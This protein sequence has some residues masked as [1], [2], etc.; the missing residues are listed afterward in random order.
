VP[1]HYRAKAQAQSEQCQRLH[2]IEIAQTNTSRRIL[3]Y[4]ESYR[5]RSNEE[6]DGIGQGWNDEEV[7]NQS[8]KL[9]VGQ[10]SQ[11]ETLKRRSRYLAERPE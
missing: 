11:P 3:E 9:V 6:E 8:Y 7:R 4:R 2:A 1:D 5:S 10:T